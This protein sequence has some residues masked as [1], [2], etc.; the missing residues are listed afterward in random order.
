MCIRDR[1]GSR[2]KTFASDLCVVEDE[3]LFSDNSI[4][5][6]AAALFSIDDSSVLFSKNAFETLYPASITKVMTALIAI[7]YGN[8]SDQVT[9]TDSAVKMCIRDRAYIVTIQDTGKYK[10]SAD[11]NAMLLE[12]VTILDKH[13]E[14][15]EGK[16]EV[17][18]NSNGDMV[19]TS[20]SESARKRFLRDYYGRKSVDELDDPEGKYPSAITAR[21]AFE[22]RKESYGLNSMKDEKGNA[23]II[24]DDLA[25]DIVNIR[26]TMGLTAYQK[27]A[28]TPITSYVSEETVVDIKEHKAQLDGVGIEE[29]TIRVYND[30]IYFAPIIGYTGKVQED[31]LEELKKSDPD[32]ELTDV[33]GRK[34]CIRDSLNCAYG[35]NRQLCPCR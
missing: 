28:T 26:Y 14:A 33:V 15:V 34:M 23:L 6:E 1:E 12:L 29:S 9:V 35:S 31:Q 4:S 8:L 10:R 25:L 18:I 32:Y 19:Y 16:F 22:K 24:P 2:A 13:G 21:E 20:A 17:T 30:S 3:S 27:Y 5:S 7:K 11:M